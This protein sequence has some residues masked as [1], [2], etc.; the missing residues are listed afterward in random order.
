MP[1]MNGYSVQVERGH[2]TL[3]DEVH[4][5]FN[6]ATHPSG[7]LYRVIAFYPA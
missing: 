4:I 3:D 1:P 7:S 2:A 5:Y 6:S